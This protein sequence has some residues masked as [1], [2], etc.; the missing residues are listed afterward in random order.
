M[1][2]T[3]VPSEVSLDQGVNFNFRINM[4]VFVLP[5]EAK[6]EP[7][8][9]AVHNEHGKL[10]IVLN[11]TGNAHIHIDKLSLSRIA[12]ETEIF[13]Q[14]QNEYIFGGEQKDWLVDI[15]NVDPKSSFRIE[16]ESNVGP[17]ETLITLSDS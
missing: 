4:P 2:I 12:D 9:T 17:I 7:D 13:A 14:S 16:A 15:G 8:I 5:R 11:N 6:P 1:V 3:E 10:Q